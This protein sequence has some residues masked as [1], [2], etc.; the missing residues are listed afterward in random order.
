M[1]V[2]VRCFAGFGIHPSYLNNIIMLSVV[3]T[4]VGLSIIIS[5]ARI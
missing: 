4:V 1:F 5:A 2:W 3:S